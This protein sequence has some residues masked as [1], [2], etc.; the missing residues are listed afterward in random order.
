[1]NFFVNFQTNNTK[2]F[3]MCMAIN[4]SIVLYIEVFASII[5]KITPYLQKCVWCILA[6]NYTKHHSFIHF[7]IHFLLM[8]IHFYFKLSCNLLEW[9]FWKSQHLEWADS[10]NVT[11]NWQTGIFKLV[12]ANNLWIF[13][14]NYNSLTVVNWA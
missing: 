10:F 12:F 11:C 8:G 2:Y 4:M 9:N 14:I 1:M 3:Q 5:K 7:S 6:H 13:T